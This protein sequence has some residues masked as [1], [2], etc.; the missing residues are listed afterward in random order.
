[1]SANGIVNGIWRS[2]DSVSGT[3]SY[4]SRFEN[5]T[6]RMTGLGYDARRSN[7]GVESND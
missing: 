7:V 3:E 1:V 6:E 5:G 4:E 2:F